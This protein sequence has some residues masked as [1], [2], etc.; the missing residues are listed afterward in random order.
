MAPGEPDA[1]AGLGFG[2][3]S[4]LIMD[5]RIDLRSCGFGFGSFFTAADFAAGLPAVFFSLFD[6]AP[7]L[8]PGPL[9]SFVVC[10]FV[11]ASSSAQKKGKC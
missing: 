5:F 8:D 1:F 9:R 7:D 10:L 2:G 6:E 3:G 4:G 11:T